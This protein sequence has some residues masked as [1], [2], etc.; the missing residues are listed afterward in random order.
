MDWE[1]GLLTQ[2]PERHS[3]YTFARDFLPT[4]VAVAGMILSGDSRWRFWLFAVLAFGFAAAG[5][6]FQLSDQV[7]D[8][9]ARRRDAAVAKREFATFR[10]WVLAFGEFVGN[11]NQSDTLHMIVMSVPDVAARHELMRVIDPTTAQ[12]LR[13]FWEYFLLRTDRRWVTVKLLEQDVSE[14]NNLVGQYYSLCVRQVFPRLPPEIAQGLSSEDRSKLEGF[15]QRHQLFVD[16]YRKYLLAL[17]ESRPSLKHLPRTVQ[18][19]DP[20]A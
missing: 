12:A 17:S 19:A 20:L 13:S 1:T 9:V 15:R 7:H 4:A 11:Q 2:E 16:G 14:F 6:Y 8:W 5:L 18:M 10:H 3:A